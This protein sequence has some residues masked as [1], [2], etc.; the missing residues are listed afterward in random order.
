MSKYRNT[1][2]LL[3]FFI[4]MLHIIF[5][6]SCIK[7]DDYVPEEVTPECTIVSPDNNDTF[8]VGSIVHLVANISGFKDDVRIRYMIDTIQLAEVLTSP[9]D[10]NW[11]TAGWDTGI[12][13]VKA[14]AYTTSPSELAEN[15]VRVILVDTIAPPQMPVPVITITPPAGTT[16]SIFYF[17]AS[18][19]YDP[20]GNIEDLRF[21]WDFDGDGSWDT[22]LTEENNFMHK[23]TH[24]SLYEVR[25]EVVDADSMIADTVKNL[26]VSHSLAPDACEGYVS[27]PHGGQIYHTVA[28]GNQ[29]WLR[30]NMNIGIMI[31][32]DSSQTNNSIIEKYCYEDDTANCTKYGGLYQWKEMVKYFPLQGIQGICPNG[33]HI[34]S[35]VEWKELEGY[36]D[37]HYGPGD[38]EWD[39]TQFRGF[40]AGKHLKSL[41]GWYA[42]GHGDNWYDFKALPGG[43]WESGLNFQE[44][45]EGAHFWTS[46]H[47]SGQNGIKRSLRFDED[48]SSRAYYWEQAAFSVRCIR[49]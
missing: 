44:E 41:L 49:D 5:I 34:P 24:P 31:P 21:R 19:S 1:S 37:T 40:D 32:S 9:F 38:P 20:D 3:I 46:T 7:E 28:I 12:H 16:D 18:T 25:L 10:F 23:Y 4:L 30:E 48:R 42:N 22:D 6:T 17:D 13:I 36:V 47:D 14:I 33:W 29:C 35:D 39:M 26:L 8:Q 2:L 43:F 27:L 11:M 15:K 45:S